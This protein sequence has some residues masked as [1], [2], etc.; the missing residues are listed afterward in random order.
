MIGKAF[1]RAVKIKHAGAHAPLNVGLIGTGCIG[2][3]YLKTRDS[4]SELN[5]KVCGSLD[6]EE[7]SRKAERFGIGDRAGPDEIIADDSIDCILNLTVPTV[8]AEVSLAALAAGKHDSRL[9][10]A[11]VVTEQAS[12]MTG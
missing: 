3:I 7:N 11:R 6:F 5:V 2:D 10:F 4:F 12:R 1:D 9:P 8:H